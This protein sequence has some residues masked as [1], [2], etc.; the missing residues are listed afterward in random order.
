M[1]KR[2]RKKQLQKLQPI[3]LTKVSAEDFVGRACYS[4]GYCFYG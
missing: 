3:D 4:I 2:Q 1:N